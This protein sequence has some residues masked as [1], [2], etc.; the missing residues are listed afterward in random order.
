MITAFE[1]NIQPDVKHDS[2]GNDNGSHGGEDFVLTGRS[3]WL[4]VDDYSVFIVNDHDGDEIRVKIFPLG[5]EMENALAEIEMPKLKVTSHE[6][7]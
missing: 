5:A 2:I 4:R 3:A 1:M 7:R 6:K